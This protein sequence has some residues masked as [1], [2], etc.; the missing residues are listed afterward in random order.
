M[1]SLL[2]LSE[3]EIQK[4]DLKAELLPFAGQAVRRREKKSESQAELETRKGGSGEDIHQ[5]TILQTIKSQRLSEYSDRLK[6]F[7]ERFCKR[8]KGADYGNLS[9]TRLLINHGAI[10]P[11]YLRWR[12]ANPETPLLILNADSHHDEYLEVNRNQ[13]SSA[14]WAHFVSSCPNTSVLHLPSKFIE[15][16]SPSNKHELTRAGLGDEPCAWHDKEDFFRQRCSKL[17]EKPGSALW[18]T[19]DYDY[20]CTIPPQNCNGRPP[21]LTDAWNYSEEIKP[22]LEKFISLIA[23]L[24]TPLTKIIPVTSPTYLPITKNF[25]PLFSELTTMLLHQYFGALGR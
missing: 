15:S 17:L 25:I 13:L 16:H 18:L 24:D 11:H 3:K 21:R 20:F 23:S 2:P 9:I 1:L 12:N 6:R 14:T 10:V 19:L 22:E 5:N 4:I 8:T 7:D